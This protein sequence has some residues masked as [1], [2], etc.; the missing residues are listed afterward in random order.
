M[1]EKELEKYKRVVLLAKDMK[2]YDTMRYDTFLNCLDFLVENDVN[3]HVKTIF[4]LTE[5][6]KFNCDKRQLHKLCIEFHNL[7]WKKEFG[8][9]GTTEYDDK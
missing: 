7:E 2:Y 5:V 8:K 3:C 4:G 1:N 9:F 6:W